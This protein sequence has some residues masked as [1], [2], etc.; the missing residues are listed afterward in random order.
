MAVTVP[1]KYQNKYYLGDLPTPTADLILQIREQK[2]ISNLKQM[3]FMFPYELVLR[4]IEENTSIRSIIKRENIDYTQYLWNLKDYQTVGTAFMYQSPRSI[5]GDGVGLGKTAEVSALLNYLRSRNEMTRFCMAVE[6]SALGQTAAELMKFTGLKVVQLDSLSAKFLKQIDKIDWSTVDGLVIKHSML[7]SDSFSKW[8]SVNLLPNGMNKIFDTFI[9]DESSILK[10][11]TTKTYRYTK[12]ICDIC[13]R[14]HFLNATAFETHIMDIYNQVDIMNPNILPKKYR[15]QREYCTYTS[16][17]YWIKQGGVPTQ[18]Y[19]WQLSGY[20]NQ[21]AFKELLRLYYFGRCKKDIGMDM[22][23]IH[24]VYEVE[25]TVDQC[26]AISKKHR[27][28]E[29]LNCPS[30]IPEINIPTSRKTVPKLERL[31]NLIENDFS[32]EKVMVYAFHTEAQRVIKEELEQIGRKVVILNGSCTDEERSDAR[33]GF[34]G[35]K[36]DVII[37]NIKKSLNLP[38]GDVCIFY[39]LITNPS[40]MFQ[41]AGRIDRNVDDRIKTYIMLIYKGT[42]EYTFFTDVV[43]SRSKYAKDLTIDAKTTVDYFIE[44]LESEGDTEQ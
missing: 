19:S 1:I 20:K 4:S 37:T 21:A 22:P 29:V 2:L 18:K 31:I 33:E 14:V 3:L 38:A 32:S 12:N 42:A 25:P 40:T 39:S 30:L 41:V 17:P 35:D 28:A 23:H 7:R 11:D 44:A 13:K 34:N 36:Y 8:L 43:K 6:N 27:Y 5:L 24:K 26:M 9:L 10:N 16:K 15:I